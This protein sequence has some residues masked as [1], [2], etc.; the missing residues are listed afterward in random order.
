MILI[1]DDKLIHVDNA[2]DV[3][4]HFGIKGMKWGRRISGN[5]VVSDRAAAR[6]S[7]KISALENRNKS[8]RKNDAKDALRNALLYGLTGNP[9]IMSSSNESRF[10]RSTKADKLRAKVNSNKNKTTYKEESKKIRDSY[11]KNSDFAKSKWKQIAKEKGKFNID[12]KIAKNMYKST[13]AIDKANEWRSK[14]GNV[15]TARELVGFYNAKKYSGKVDKLA[16]KKNYKAEKKKIDK[17]YSDREDRIANTKGNPNKLALKEYKNGQDHLAARKKL[18]DQY[19][20][21]KKKTGR[22]TYYVRAK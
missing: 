11:Y 8:T 18:K 19:K 1:E 6:A 21:S 7:R 9:Y 17:K 10:H 4:E 14:I 2:G 20:Q 12:S 15:T 16:S 5:Y 22:T 3:I 13:K